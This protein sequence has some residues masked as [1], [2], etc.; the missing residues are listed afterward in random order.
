[1]KKNYLEPT[2][3]VVELDL[4]CNLLADSDLEEGELE[5]GE[6]GVGSGSIGDTGGLAKRES[7]WDDLW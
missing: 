6:A 5:S 1:M 3:K 4:D 7:L 2:E